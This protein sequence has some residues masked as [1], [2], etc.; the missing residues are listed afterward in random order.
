MDDAR[1]S[2]LAVLSGSHIRT[3]VFTISASPEESISLQFSNISVTKL[4]LYD[5]ASNF[6]NKGSLSFPISYHIRKVNN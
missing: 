1:F 4:L 5:L 2:G 6:H 3:S